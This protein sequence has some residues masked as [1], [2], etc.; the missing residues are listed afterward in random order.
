VYFGG[1]VA[2]PVFRNVVDESLKHLN[3]KD[4]YAPIKRHP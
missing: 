1:D 2:A 4:Q 3:I